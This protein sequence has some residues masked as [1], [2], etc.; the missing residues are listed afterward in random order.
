MYTIPILKIVSAA[1]PNGSNLFDSVN[2]DTLLSFINI[3]LLVK[4]LLL[5][6]CSIYDPVP[7]LV[8]PNNVRQFIHA[9]LDMEEKTVDDLWETFREEIWELEF[10]VDDLT[11]TLGTRYIP[12][13][14]KHGPSNDIAF[15]N[16]SPPTRTCLDPGCDQEVSQ[17]PLVSRPREL[18]EQLHVPVT[19]FTN[20]FG[21]VTGHSISL[22]CRSEYP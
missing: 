22:Y 2:L 13:F 12:L 21:A 10:D 11:E 8:L 17:Y 7:P 14:L 5:K 9:S 3:A 16:F 19:V 15:Y 4:P 20:S 18:R 6:H 1:S